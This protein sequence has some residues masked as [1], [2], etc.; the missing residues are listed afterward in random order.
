MYT[1]IKLPND[2][3]GISDERLNYAPTIGLLA[4]LNGRPMPDHKWAMNA[5]RDLEY[6]VMVK[7]VYSIGF[8][9]FVVGDQI[10]VIDRNGLAD[11]LPARLPAI[12]K[13]DWQ[14]GHFEREL[15]GGYLQTLES[16]RNLIRDPDL[17]QY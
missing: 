9:G 15:P 6:H 3:N 8:Y 12:R 16:G 4:A 7:A 17:A 14:I 10:Y 13:A 2:P 11:P 1:G 5:R